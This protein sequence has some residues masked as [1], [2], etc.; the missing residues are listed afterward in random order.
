M[1]VLFYFFAL[2]RVR[3]GNNRKAISWTGKIWSPAC[4]LKVRLNRG[5]FRSLITTV[6][7][8]G[9]ALF[10]TTVF[11]IWNLSI[12]LNLKCNNVLHWEA[13]VLR[14]K[15]RVDFPYVFAAEES[16]GTKTLNK[17][18]DFHEDS[19]I[20]ILLPPL[21]NSLCLGSTSAIS[22]ELFRTPF[23]ITTFSSQNFM[24]SCK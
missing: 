13:V 19:C 23:E 4:V 8:L 12:D 7:C 24:Y 1:F 16:V 6:N 14:P 5:S 9:G 10:Q 3:R 18:A 2:K 15:W 22:I 20:E 17:P 11:E 21:N